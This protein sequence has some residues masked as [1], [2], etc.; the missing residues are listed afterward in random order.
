ME[1][2]PSVFVLFLNVVQGLL[3]LFSLR[4]CWHKRMTVREA[5]W[6]VV[7]TDRGYVHVL[8]K[9]AN[10][11]FYI[12]L[13]EIKRVGEVSQNNS[14]QLIGNEDEKKQ[15]LIV[16]EVRR[17]S[18]SIDRGQ[19]VPSLKEA[20]ETHHAETHI[21]EN[22]MNTAFMVAR[23]SI[24]LAVVAKFDWARFRFYLTNF[25]T[26]KYF[27]CAG[28]WCAK[29]FITSLTMAET[30]TMLRF[31]WEFRA[32]LLLLCVWR[33]AWLAVFLTDAQ[34]VLIRPIH[35]YQSLI[36]GVHDYF[37]NTCVILFHS[38]ASTEVEGE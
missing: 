13:L 16:Q 27:L 20:A 31:R 37:N 12:H 21:D 29:S 7:H 11:N 9:T 14:D 4:A 36:K 28:S 35:V 38:V 19:F 22:K 25:V 2:A 18:G 33:S 17:K 32:T 34:P 10:N 30:G 8:H 6:L 5:K 3:H 26:N 1:N 15:L 24:W 23:R